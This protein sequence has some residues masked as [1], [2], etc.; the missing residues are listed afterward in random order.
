MTLDAKAE[1]PE[2]WKVTSGRLEPSDTVDFDRT[3]LFADFV[4]DPL[5]RHGVELQRLVSGLRGSGR[6]P[7]FVLARL[8]PAR[9]QIIAVSPERGSAPTLVTPRI[10]DD[11]R[12]AE[13]YVFELRLQLLG[14]L[15]GISR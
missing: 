14:A 3:D 5:A 10:F 6:L 8:A 9:W 4:R 13:H 7:R 11:L 15:D 1:Q 12:A 2:M